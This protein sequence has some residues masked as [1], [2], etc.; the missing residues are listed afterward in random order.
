MPNSTEGWGS[1]EGRTISNTAFC[2]VLQGIVE[3]NKRE[4]NSSLLSYV[5]L[6]PSD[7]M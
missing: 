7:I 3:G 4:T 5:S 2:I 1:C 6:T